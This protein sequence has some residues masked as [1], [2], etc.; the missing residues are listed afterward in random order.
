MEGAAPLRYKLSFSPE[1]MQPTASQQLYSTST[2]TILYRWTEAQMYAVRIA[3]AAPFADGMNI[4]SAAVYP[5]DSYSGAGDN[6]A[7]W[8][9]TGGGGGSTH[10][11]RP[12]PTTFRSRWPYRSPPTHI[13][14][15]TVFANCAERRR[16]GTE[17][18]TPGLTRSLSF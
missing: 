2:S 1:G 8:Q 18:V 17:D 5:T 6:S 11:T 4:I 7:A 9:G 14:T 13:P 15:H 12:T 16:M 3:F 10:E